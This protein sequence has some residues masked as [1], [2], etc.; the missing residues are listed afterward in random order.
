MALPTKYRKQDAP[1][2]ELPFSNL[3]RGG[4]VYCATKR[5][6][7]LPSSFFQMIVGWWSLSFWKS[8]AR[9]P[10]IE[11]FLLEVHQ[12]PIF[13]PGL[14]EWTNFRLRWWTPLA[15]WNL[16]STCRKCIPTITCSASEG[17]WGHNLR[18]GKL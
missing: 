18:W 3:L 15:R 1:W 16:I 13:F 14:L 5:T 8:S 7:H 17:H 9:E 2:L 12:Q 6:S 4:S 11:I 10:A